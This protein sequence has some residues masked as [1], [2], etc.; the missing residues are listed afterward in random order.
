MFVD[1]IVYCCCVYVHVCA[2][3]SHTQAFLTQEDLDMS[4]SVRTKTLDILNHVTLYASAALTCGGLVV[5]RSLEAGRW[6]VYR[7]ALNSK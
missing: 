7:D 3:L 4:L 1:V 6:F 5:W 2:C